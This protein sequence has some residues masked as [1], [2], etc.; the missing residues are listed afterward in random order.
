MHSI[1]NRVWG[2]P[3]GV[4]L[5]YYVKK[6]Y[7]PHFIT[8]M[9]QV[10]F[11]RRI[12]FIGKQ[13]L[14]KRVMRKSMENEMERIENFEIRE[15]DRFPH[16][17]TTKSD[18]PQTPVVENF[19]E[20][21]RKSTF[22]LEN[23][24][25]IL[26]YPVLTLHSSLPFASILFKGTGEEKYSS[27]FSCILSG[28]R[29][30]SVRNLYSGIAKQPWF[31]ENTLTHESIQTDQ[32]ETTDEEKRV[33]SSVNIE[34]KKRFEQSKRLVAFRKKENL[35]TS[36]NTVVKNDPHLVTCSQKDIRYGLNESRHDFIVPGNTEAV[37]LYGK[38]QIETLIPCPLSEK[39]SR[40][41]SDER[42]GNK[43]YAQRKVE[44]SLQAITEGK[45]LEAPAG[46][47]HH[48]MPLL[49]STK[50]LQKL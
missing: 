24:Q 34:T 17:L 1:K 11:R 14:Q 38:Q 4:K 46:A 32:E 19:K 25:D 7:V 16:S 13:T 41:F 10:T 5:V 8:T 12:S 26:T 39:K 23:D 15:G 47:T 36:L 37:T 9:P 33:F 50:K 28:R 6:G 20:K 48:D 2:D 31:N 3:R 49:P 29:L 45:Q 21:K 27:R 44:G 43:E 30:K 22:K 18:S 35:E 40:P 42:G